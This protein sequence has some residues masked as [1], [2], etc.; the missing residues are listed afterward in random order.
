MHIHHAPLDCCLKARELVDWVIKKDKLFFSNYG[1]TG[2]LLCAL[3]RPKFPCNQTA[4]DAQWDILRTDTAQPSGLFLLKQSMELHLLTAEG[5]LRATACADSLTSRN[6]E[7]VMQCQSC[8]Y[9]QLVFGLDTIS[10][11]PSCGIHHIRTAFLVTPLQGSAVS[12]WF[13]LTRRS[14]VWRCLYARI[15][16]DDYMTSLKAYVV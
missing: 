15:K 16:L 5:F 14:C 2:T 11:P 8:S 13:Q 1:R 7:I 12:E 10:W 3:W 9:C 4:K 6:G